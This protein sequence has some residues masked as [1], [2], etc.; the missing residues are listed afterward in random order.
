M[1]KEF[2]I[3]EK[4]KQFIHF[5][6][7]LSPY[8]DKEVI[9]ILC[10]GISTLFGLTGPYMAK[11]TIDYAYANRDLLLFNVLVLAGIIIYFFSRLIGVI[12]HY[13]GVYINLRLSFDLHSRFYGYLHKL[14][15]RFFQS[16]TTGEQMYRLGPDIEGVVDLVTGTIPTAVVSILRL[17]FLLVIAFW[18]NWKLTLV[19]IG[20][21][22]IFYLHAHYFSK[23]QYPIQKEIKKKSQ[24]ISKG[25]Q[26]AISQIKLLKA[27]GREKAE[28]RRYLRDL[29]ERIRIALK[30]IRIGILSRE[31]GRLLNM[32]AVTGISYYAGYQVIK[33]T[34]TL[35]TLIALTM[36]IFQ[37]FNLLK[38]F[39][40]I[41]GNIMVESVSIE[42]VNETLDA[43]IEIKDVPDAIELNSIRGAI[44][45][46]DV[47]FGYKSNEPV[48]KDVSFKIDPG[49]I[50]ALV[51]PS[52]IGK[53]TVVNLILRLYDP[54]KGSVLIDRYDL[55]KI[56]LKSLKDQIGIALQESFLTSGTIKDNIRYGK[57]TAT[58]EEIIEAAKIADAHSFIIALPNGYDTEVGEKGCRLSEGQRERIAIARAII[59]KPKILI[60]DEATASVGSI[61]ETTIQK[62]LK[63]SSKGRTTIIIAHRL[64]TIIN[65]DIIFVLADTGIVEKGTHAEL[66]TQNGLYRKLY[67]RQL[68]IR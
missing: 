45:F 6:K 66:L 47:T 36:Y 15:L 63:V 29:I 39:G 61:S 44:E 52:G 8:W 14:S 25:L 57:P 10:I 22:P 3:K 58:E 65:A 46:N 23:K 56:T 1:E 34:M 53:T 27:F 60:L 54:W 16:R 18:L 67:E 55:K 48:L 35:G 11:L 26:E 41:Y 20:I 30:N 31:S 40:G 64:S 13:L 50:V 9:L 33:G 28:V 4:L 42:R 59:K 19:A 51:G 38:S 68:E 2:G 49:M 17:V 5:S 32:L 43:K 21:T 62:A 12:Q 37:L 7:Y 24:D